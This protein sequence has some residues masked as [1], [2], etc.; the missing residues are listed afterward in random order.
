MSSDAS[1]RSRGTGINGVEYPL[2]TR[3]DR[4]S[5]VQTYF[6]RIDDTKCQCICSKYIVNR[7]K[8][9]QSSCVNHVTLLHAGK[10]LASGLASIYLIL[11]A[12]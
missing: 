4:D 11:A 10:S 7:V 6:H 8:T 9:G 1:S 5:I 2:L 12:V 3:V